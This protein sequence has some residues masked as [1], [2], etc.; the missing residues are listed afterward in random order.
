[1]PDEHIYEGWAKLQ[2]SLLEIKG[3]MRA[4]TCILEM[5]SNEQILGR[6]T[7]LNFASRV[8]KIVD[9]ELDKIPPFMK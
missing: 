4:Q 8:T 9:D 1:M 3:E 2:R 7:F 6:A 5:H